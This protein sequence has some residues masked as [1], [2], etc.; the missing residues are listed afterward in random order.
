MEASSIIHT[1]KTDHKCDM[2]QR[3]IKGE[4]I[5]GEGSKRILRFCSLKCKAKWLKCKLL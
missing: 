4:P 3:P 1:T 5:Y 2:C